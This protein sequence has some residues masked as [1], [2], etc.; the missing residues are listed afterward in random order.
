MTKTGGRREWSSLDF[1]I[2]VLE[3]SLGTPLPHS[4]CLIIPISSDSGDHMGDPCSRKDV[5]LLERTSP[6]WTEEWIAT[7]SPIQ[8]MGDNFGQA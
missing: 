4:D 5:S 3:S 2:Q 6:L 8:K 7:V 1:S